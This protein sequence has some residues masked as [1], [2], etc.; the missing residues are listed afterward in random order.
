MKVLEAREK[1]RTL[2]MSTLKSN[3]SKAYITSSSE[4][5]AHREIFLLVLTFSDPENASR[6]NTIRQ[7]WA[8]TT[9]IRGYS[10][11]T[12]FVLGK[13]SSEATQLEVLKE[14]QEHQDLIEGAFPDSPENQTLKT[15]TALE[16]AVTFCPGARFILK[17]DEQMFVNLANLVDY[18]LSLRTHFENIYLG[19][20]VHQE[21]PNRDPQSP[22]FVPKQLYPEKYYPDYCSATAF[23]ISQDVARMIYVTSHEVPL[24]MPPGVFVGICTKNAG[25]TPTHSSR[26]SGKK[27]I[28]YNRC[29][30][31][32]IFT[33]AVS[34]DGQLVQEWEEVNDGKTCSLLENY[35]GLLSCRV[36]TYLD[37]FKYLNIDALQNE[38][39]H[40][41]D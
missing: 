34:R 37:G 21:V 39:L 41:A 8:N 13:P 7:T 32:F 4:A 40:F 22:K 5:C 15:A 14:S 24:S 20:V 16:W 23:V 30:Y 1:A 27:H 19:R 36:M 11:V 10:T 9:D 17:T 6:R 33:S 29:C 38:A 35:Y 28:Q 2:D 18:L 31:K 25:V 26:F 3:I 12:L